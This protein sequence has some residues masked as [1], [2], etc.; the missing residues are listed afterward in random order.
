MWK[1]CKKNA[2]LTKRA[3]YKKCVKLLKR[4]IFSNELKFEES[5]IRSNNLG[6]IYKHVN[7]R[8]TRKSGFAPLKNSKDEVIVDNKEKVEL[9]NTH[10]V[11]AGT[12]DDGV[13]PVIN[14]TTDD[15]LDSICFD[16]KKY[17]R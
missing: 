6:A 12:V 13:L 15:S 7:A 1:S 17:Q 10:F 3:K 5:V 16:L 4:E 9:L 11:S 2:S 14:F 8:L